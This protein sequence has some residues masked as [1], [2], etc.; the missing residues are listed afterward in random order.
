MHQCRFKPLNRSR[1]WCISLQWLEDQERP[2]WN[3]QKYFQ[4]HLEARRAYRDAETR[5][6]SNNIL[7]RN[8]CDT[9]LCYYPLDFSSW[10]VR[11]LTK[12]VGFFFLFYF[13]QIAAFPA[14]SGS[15]EHTFSRATS[16]LYAH[17]SYFSDSSRLF[18]T[19]TKPVIFCSCN[20]I[21]TQRLW[22]L[23][24]WSKAQVKV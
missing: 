20:T 2:N 19:K 11:A 15:L 3:V 4:P 21:S 5:L 17:T 14:F 6:K 18:T 24:H 9:W 7:L 1:I 13:L 10:T 23:N 12:W 22:K 8:W 16:Y